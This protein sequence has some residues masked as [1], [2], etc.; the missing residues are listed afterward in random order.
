[1]MELVYAT[2][3]MV[4]SIRRD[5][6]VHPVMSLQYI[7]VGRMFVTPPYPPGSFDYSVPGSTTNSTDKMQT[8]NNLYLRPNEEG[9]GRFVY[10]INTIQRNSV[11]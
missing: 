7:V 5:G 6:G 9:G 11:H 4:N 3:V 1:M 10:N 8:F 2:N